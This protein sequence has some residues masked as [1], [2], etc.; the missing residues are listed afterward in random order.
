MV[1]IDEMQISDGP[2]RV[3]PEKDSYLKKAL[4]ANSKIFVA[5]PS[6][7]GDRWCPSIGSHQ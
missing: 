1:V 5:S 4:L 7:V 2:K 6:G 3:A